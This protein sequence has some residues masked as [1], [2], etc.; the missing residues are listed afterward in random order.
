MLA[1]EFERIVDAGHAADAVA[2]R[3]TR[4][5]D[6]AGRDLAV[7]G[8]DAGDAATR[9]RDAEHLAALVDVQSVALRGLDDG[10]DGEHGIGEAGRRL[11]ACEPDSI[12]LELRPA[13]H[14]LL[15]LERRGLDAEAGLHRDGVAER[16]RLLGRREEHVPDLVE[17]DRPAELLLG[18]VEHRGAAHGQPDRDLVR[19]VL[20]HVCGRVLRRAAADPALLDE[21]DVAEAELG[22]EVRRARAHDPSAD[23]DRIRLSDHVPLLSVRRSAVASTSA[24]PSAPITTP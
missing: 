1:A 17:A 12:E 14:D 18:V 11:V 2:P 3:A 16:L 5:D 22:E 13:A 24:V 9:G 19:V 10:L 6:D 15:G 23:H 21:H 4:V 20:P 8:D 7:S